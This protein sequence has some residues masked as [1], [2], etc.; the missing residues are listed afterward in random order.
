MEN[1]QKLYALKEL[2]DEYGLTYYFLRQACLNGDLKH[3]RCG[4]KF[5]V[6]GEW[7]ENFLEE[8]SCGGRL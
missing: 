5:K 6:R 7:M 2:A 4:V 1:R 8:Q 3:I